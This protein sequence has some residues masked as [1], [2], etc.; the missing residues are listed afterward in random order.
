MPLELTRSRIPAPAVGSRS[1]AASGRDIERLR[2]EGAFGEPSR[3][4]GKAGE[5]ARFAG[6]FCADRGLIASVDHDADDVGR[7]EGRLCGLDRRLGR[8]AAEAD[9]NRRSSALR[10]VICP[11]ARCSR[12]SIAGAQSMITV[13][14]SLWASSQRR[15]QRLGGPQPERVLVLAGQVEPA[16]VVRR[17]LPGRRRRRVCCRWRP[18]AASASRRE[19]CARPARPRRP[20]R[21]R[22][23]RPR[24]PR[25]RALR[26]RPRPERSTRR[27]ARPPRTGRPET[28]PPARGWSPDRDGSCGAG[29]EGASPRARRLHAPGARSAAAGGLRRS[30]P[31]PGGVVARRGLSLLRRHVRL[32]APSCG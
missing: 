4:S 25:R 20:T 22:P 14:Q 24:S 16:D 3:K 27:I 28:R 30:R 17:R 19:R 15:R 5:P 31:A 21:R 32:N 9:K 18:R 7:S 1:S 29:S 10:A 23:P 12:S 6:K 2:S 26:R 11:G 8:L 13:S